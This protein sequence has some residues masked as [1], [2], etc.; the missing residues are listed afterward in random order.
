MSKSK[1]E[2]SGIGFLVAD[3][4]LGIMICNIIWYILGGRDW[5]DFK[6]NQ[7][8]YNTGSVET[9][10]KNCNSRYLNAFD[11]NT[12]ESTVWSPTA[13]QVALGNALDTADIFKAYNSGYKTKDE[14]LDIMTDSTTKWFEESNTS[15]IPNEIQQYSEGNILSSVISAN[16]DKGR[17]VW[18]LT[19]TDKLA[20]SY[21]LGNGSV[22]YEGSGYY[23][24][25]ENYVAY[26]VFT[27]D[28]SQI[29]YFIMPTGGAD[30]P[31]VAKTIAYNK[32]IKSM[33]RNIKLC[34]P[35]VNVTAIDNC[36]GYVK[37]ITN[38]GERIID[39]K[40]LGVTVINQFEIDSSDYEDYSEKELNCD[41]MSDNYLFIKVNRA[42]GMITQMG[43][44]NGE[45]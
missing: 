35:N 17:S 45:S 15:E 20:S 8:H 14:S 2:S 10:V 12:S 22:M 3:I 5:I 24:T 36:S 16:I 41:V 38:N 27:E 37:G 18:G 32:D 1:K 39:E 29:I 7:Y 6:R 4:V 25:G 11:F 26:G 13:P 33:P 30:I 28:K 44:V 34:I 19:Y 21:N 31:S 23:G 40:E 43:I 42:S 9:F